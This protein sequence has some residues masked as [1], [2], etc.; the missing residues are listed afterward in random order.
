MTEWPK[1]VERE[2]LEI[3]GFIAA[4]GRLPGSRHLEVVT[5]G[6]KPDYIVKDLRTGQEYGVELTSVYV[7]DRSVPDLHMRDEV[8]AVSIPYD[9][10]E[11][12]RYRTRLAGAII[13]K[14]CK[15]RKGYDRTRPLILAIYVNEYISIYLREA[16]L[17]QFVGRYAGL[18]EA[19]TPFTEV[20][21]WNL[22]NDGVFRAT[23][24]INDA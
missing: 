24:T 11:L 22:P 16:E 4:Y 13:D 12:E 14:I 3:T 6:E 17:Q 2:G 1:K 15:A 23:P 18:F 8:S 9:E 19:M 20:V 5:K 7:D 21:F 10:R